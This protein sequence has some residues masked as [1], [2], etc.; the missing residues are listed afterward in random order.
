MHRANGGFLLLDA[1]ELLRQFM[2]WDVLEARAALPRAL[3]RKPC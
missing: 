3:D 2:S 1:D